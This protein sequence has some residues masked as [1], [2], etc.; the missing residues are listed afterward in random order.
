MSEYTLPL[1]LVQC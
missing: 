1:M